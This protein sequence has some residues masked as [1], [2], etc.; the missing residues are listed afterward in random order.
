MSNSKM[1]YFIQL[2]GMIRYY[3]ECQGVGGK[4]GE[5]SGKRNDDIQ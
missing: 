3:K 4:A 5:A 2:N 1:I